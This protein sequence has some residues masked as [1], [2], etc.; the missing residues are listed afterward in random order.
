MRTYRLTVNFSGLAAVLYNDLPNLIVQW[1]LLGLFEGCTEIHLTAS[2]AKPIHFLI[3]QQ[4]SKKF[5]LP[6]TLPLALALKIDTFNEFNERPILFDPGRWSHL[7]LARRSKS[8]LFLC[9]HSR[10]ATFSILAARG[11]RLPLVLGSFS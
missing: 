4:F 8:I 10:L 2:A 5:M 7:P 3:F 6:P 1:W 11:S 9:I